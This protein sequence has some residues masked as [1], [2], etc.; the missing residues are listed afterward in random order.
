MAG[1]WI[2]L[3]ALYVYVACRV[4]TVVFVAI[5]NRFTHNSL[6][7]DLTIWDGEWFLRAVRDGYPSHLPM[8]QGHVAANP[9]AF[10]PFYPL[11]VRVIGFTGI[12]P[13]VIALVVSAA[14]GATAVVAVGLLARRLAGDEA[15]TRAALLF[16]ICPGAFVFSLAY[17][18]GIVITCVA[19]GLICLLDRR[20]VAAGLLGLIATASSPVGLAVLLSC[21]WCAGRSVW[22]E[23]RFGAMTSL[24]IAPIGFASY[25]AYLW[26]HTGNLMAWRLTERGGW[27]SYPSLIYPV[28]IVATFV[29]NPLA[30]TM[31]GQI[32]FFGTVAAVIGIAL[33]FREHQPPPVIL[34]GLGAVVA[35]AI[36]QPVGLRPRFLL[37]AF[38][39]II[40]LATRYQGRTYRWL[41][42]VSAVLLAGFTVLELASRAVFP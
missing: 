36:S 40:A 6:L 29:T 32:L 37:L 3:T 16:A 1:R 7:Y 17:T 8:I 24:L 20:W 28:R 33:M 31:T 27:Q 9:I 41:V 26:I 10:F 25:M 23:R 19:L 21:A 5:A 11:V 4:I 42:A 39:M 30:P 15:G 34:Y 38:P 12:S 14:A 13:G 18:E 2:P 22:T 35:A